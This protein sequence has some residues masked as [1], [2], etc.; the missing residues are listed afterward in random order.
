M[1][2][3]TLLTGLL[4]ALT[5]TL[6]AGDFFVY[7]SKNKDGAVTPKT[8]EAA[9][10]KAGFTVADNRDMNGPYKKQ[11]GSTS[12]TT[13]NLFTLYHPAIA[14][15]LVNKY[16]QAGVFVPMSMGIYQKEGEDTIYAAVLTAATQAKILGLASVDP[17][18]KELESKIQSAL[19]TAMPKGADH[20]P[21]YAVKAPRGDL[22]TQFSLEVEEDEAEDMKEE[23]ELLIEDGLKPHGFVLANFTNYNYEL[24]EEETTESDFLFYDTYSICKLKVIFATSKERPETGAFAPCT[25]AI[26]KK[27]DEDKIV[28]A[29]PSVYNWLSSAAITD[30]E[31]IDALLKAQ[32]DMEKVVRSATE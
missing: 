1:K 5:A 15:K 9:F 28:V 3:T 26:Y 7:G 16:P 12:F 11:F 13:Y 20:S 29:Y 23:I 24:T 8:I 17:L 19:K 21:T 2:L 14:K 25:L 18:L 22:L 30:Q 10:S 4:F 6:S 32:K 31:S 27:K